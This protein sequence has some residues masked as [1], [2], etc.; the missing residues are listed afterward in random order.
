MKSSSEEMRRINE[1]DTSS[2]DLNK[3]FNKLNAKNAWELSKDIKS[4]ISLWNNKEVVGQLYGPVPGFPSGSWWGIRMDC[5]RDHVHDPFNESVQDGPV[6]AIS[7]CTSHSNEDVDFGDLLTFTGQQYVRGNLKNESLIL[8]FQNKIPVRLVRGYS[9]SNNFAPKT[10]YR[11]D[12]LY[13]VTAYWIGVSSNSTKY[14][15]FA[16]ARLHRQEPAPWQC[17]FSLVSQ[18]SYSNVSKHSDPVTRYA[19]R[20][21]TQSICDISDT[22]GSELKKDMN[23]SGGLSEKLKPSLKRKSDI[24]LNLS[25]TGSV[26]PPA[27]VMSGGH[28]NVRKS[29]IV[30]RRVSKK[31]SGNLEVASEVKTSM[32]SNSE[33]LL[34][35]VGRN[36]SSKLIPSKLQN[37]N[38]SI[39]TDLYDSSDNTQRDKKKAASTTFCRGFKPSGICRRVLNYR[40]SESALT[41]GK[42]DSES[43]IE[44]SQLSKQSTV[45]N[46][47]FSDQS[48]VSSEDTG[49]VSLE[50][51]NTELLEDTSISELIHRKENSRDVK[52]K[53]IHRLNSQTSHSK[54][55]IESANQSLI[56][57]IDSNTVKEHI[58]RLPDSSADSSRSNVSNLNLIDNSTKNV[59]LNL[60]HSESTEHSYVV[61]SCRQMLRCYKANSTL[62]NLTEVQSKVVS[63][64]SEEITDRSEADNSE[65][66]TLVSPVT[67]KNV[68]EDDS[69]LIANDDLRKPQSF[70]N[71]L[72]SLTPDK[73][74]NLIIKEKYHPLAK[75]L[76]GNMIGLTT[77]ESTILKTYD[78]LMSCSRTES[79]ENSR[80]KNDISETKKLQ[81][82]SDQIVDRGET[83]N[84]IFH[85]HTNSSELA[86]CDTQQRTLRHAH[87]CVDPLNTSQRT[88]RQKIDKDAK[89]S[90]S[91]M[92]KNSLQTEATC[93]K[94][95]AKR[96][97]KYQA[98]TV[99]SINESV[100]NPRDQTCNNDIGQPMKQDKKS[101]HSD[102]TRPMVNFKVVHDSNHLSAKMRVR[103]TR[104]LESLKIPEIKSND[105]NQ[106]SML[107]SKNLS[108]VEITARSTS[109]PAT[110][111]R[112]KM[113]RKRRNEIMNLVIDA[114]IGPK[115]R[116]PRTRR[117]RPMNLIRTRKRY[118]DDP[119]DGPAYPQ[120]RPKISVKM[121]LVSRSD[122]SKR[123]RR[124]KSSATNSRSMQLR[125]VNR[126]KVT[127]RKHKNVRCI[128]SKALN[129]RNSRNLK[130]TRLSSIKGHKRKTRQSNHVETS[131]FMSTR[132]TLGC[133]YEEV[134]RTKP[135]MVDAMTQCLLSCM[136]SV[137]NSF[138]SR[139]TSTDESNCHILHDEQQTVVKVELIDLVDVK[140]ESLEDDIMIFDEENH[141][142]SCYP[143]EEGDSERRSV[144]NKSFKSF[145]KAGKNVTY[146]EGKK[147]HG[148]SKFE[149]HIVRSKST[150]DTEFQS[151]SQSNEGFVHCEEHR[152][153]AFVPVNSLDSHLRIARL[154]SIGFKPIRPCL[155]S[156]CSGK[157]GSN[158]GHQR[159]RSNSPKVTGSSAVA[160]RVVN[161]EYD[162]YT[163]E[164]NNIVGYMD[165]E[166]HYQD[167]EDEDEH[168]PYTTLDESFSD[169]ITV[170]KVEFT[171]IL[172]K[173][174]CITDSTECSELEENTCWHSEPNNEQSE[175]EIKDSYSILPLEDDSDVPWH[176]WRKVTT[177]EQTYWVGW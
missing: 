99:I 66:R 176:G 82:I 113:G 157:Y 14:H 32:V 58:L 4:F 147:D 75:L 10:G 18:Q 49:Q 149:R 48:T 103:Q 73:V 11:Y 53:S 96:G 85:K 62:E 93:A 24:T 17:N 136:P 169:E 31:L 45:K 132:K 35:S 19:F 79:D 67:R 144:L 117:L 6:G 21:L 90:F 159:T 29:A 156:Y 92:K 112:T 173:S 55:S 140:S 89:Q 50:G 141:E 54:S 167:I 122:L 100:E 65:N 154:K 128:K 83:E 9:L 163:S 161:E 43:K 142:P 60:K 74:L 87:Q 121:K 145:A 133:Q 34:R 130:M 107:Q 27:K 64:S 166:L 124:L 153:S 126:N 41:P 123:S 105:L 86:R 84:R 57:D 71:S 2:E 38:I 135:R 95:Q 8:S 108:D 70:F 91:S 98:N 164:E 28:K 175:E 120:K 3:L 101:C 109:K 44:T 78:E 39:R 115:V 59:K 15:K 69:F 76:M 23:A 155:H 47:T 118:G 22:N 5:S 20:K 127:S 171:K 13:M 170:H 125:N 16:L 137:N 63:E 102:V 177:D 131:S 46:S 146:V 30:T 143:R 68:E 168:N 42:N 114:N 56:N 40:D 88:S 97:K 80:E 151:N 52:I 134:E 61:P 106:G 12:G 51:R 104:L 129:S 25:N 26:L 77:G 81:M 158:C 165:E 152:T 174:P 150:T 111:K 94:L 148:Y 116:G 37:T 172:E 33:L 160:R 36:C 162:K 139:M 110:V 72:D 138:Q 7:V 1:L 119:A